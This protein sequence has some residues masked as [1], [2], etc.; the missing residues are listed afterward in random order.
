MRRSTLLLLALLLP[1]PAHADGAAARD[2]VVIDTDMGMDDLVTLALALQS[3][4]VT[5]ASVV[6]VDGVAS[7]AR[8]QEFLGRLLHHFNRGDVALWGASRARRETPPFRTF[9]DRAVDRALGAGPGVKARPFSAAAYRVGGKSV[10]LVLGPLTNLAAALRSQPTLKQAI[11]RVVV[12]GPPEAASNWNARRDPAA[13]KAVLASGLPLTFVAPDHAGA[14]Q[15]AALSGDSSIAAALVARLLRDP[16]VKAH[17]LKS[18]LR[19]TDELVWLYLLEPR[20]FT[21]GRVARPTSAQG[22]AA[23]LGRLLR[24]GRQARRSVVYASKPLPVGALRPD[25]A[26]RRDRIVANNGETEWRA[27]LLLNDLHQHLGAYSLV[28][29][30]MGLRAAELLNAPPHVM[31]VFSETAASPP[32]SCL[33]DGVIVATGSTPGRSL[34]HQG[35]GRA[36]STRVRFRYNGRSVTLSLKTAYQHRIARALSTL[37][38]RFGLAD[39]RYWSGVRGQGLEIW[40]KWHRR[41]LFDVEQR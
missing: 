36:G 16:R 28:G 4:E 9:A 41:D 38:Q 6:A 20:L 29:V 2:A 18:L 34:F 37:R 7:A 35:K 40:E 5:V 3:P 27:Q 33:N 1:V 23:L 13:W 14:K 31:E 25:L 17:Y 30:K 11:A 39:H 19:F 26:R 21:P 22:I 32:V 12:S 10:V 15:A 8:S 24:E